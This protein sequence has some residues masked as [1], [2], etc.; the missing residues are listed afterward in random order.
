MDAKEPGPRGSA[1]RLPKKGQQVT[2]KAMPGYVDGE[3]LEVLTQDKNIDGKSI[4][5]SKDDPKIVLK[6]AKSGKTCIHKPDACFY[7]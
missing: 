6:S 2:W 7:D 4:K 1:D 5:A 3:V